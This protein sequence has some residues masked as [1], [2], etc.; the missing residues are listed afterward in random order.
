MDAD[1]D[2]AVSY[3]KK[4]EGILQMLTILNLTAYQWPN[5]SCA[6]GKVHE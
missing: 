3:F 5:P 2:D 4:I 6:P 1:A